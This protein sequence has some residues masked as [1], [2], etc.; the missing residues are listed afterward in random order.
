M[1][2]RWI[3]FII[4]VVFISVG[5]PSG[6]LEEENRD[7]F[8]NRSVTKPPPTTRAK[9]PDQSVSPINLPNLGTASEIANK[10]WLNTDHP[11]HLT[12]LKGKV[13]LLKMWTF[14]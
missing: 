4:L 2:Y 3:A 7:K 11:L 6:E 8:E 1:K 5:C 10:V 14:G 12:D 9:N 13:V